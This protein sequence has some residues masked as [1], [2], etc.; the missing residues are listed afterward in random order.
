M[1]RLKMK[2]DL[3]KT[4]KTSTIKT[5]VRGKYLK[6]AGQNNPASFN[7]RIQHTSPMKD[8]IT[9]TILVTTKAGC[10]SK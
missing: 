8:T 10:C 7:Y 6:T 2:S 3:S 4:V 9:V 5:R 1:D